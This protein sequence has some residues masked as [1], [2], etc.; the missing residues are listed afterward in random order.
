MRRDILN[1][2]FWLLI[3]DFIGISFGTAIAAFGLCF[4]LI[5][6][7][8]APGGVSALAQVLFYL[9][10][11]QVGTGILV[12]NIPLFLIGIATLGRMFGVKTVFAIFMLGL[13]SNLFTSSFIKSLDFLSPFIFVIAENTISFTNETFLGVVSG[14]V[15]LGLGLGTVINF[16]GSCGS[17]D[18]PALILKKYFGTSIGTGYLLIDT[19]IIL[20]AGILMKNPN[21][22]L[23]SLVALFVTSK[24]TDKMMRGVVF[25]KAVF[26]M[27]EKEDEIKNAILKNINRGCTL[28]YAQGG[29][30]GN[31]KKVI[32]AV[33]NI[34]ELPKLKTYIYVIDPKA[35]V[36]VS[37]VSEVLGEGFKKM[38]FS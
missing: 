16:N 5:P 11:I 19:G 35:F 2:S 8:A 6:F 14:A 12:C 3:R 31:N 28:F 13:F 18:I 30:Y 37:D 36:I 15:L 29:F 32:Y 17:T 26:I 34:H 10:D 33:T 23:W 1:A 24:I 7:K 22:I 9:F 27:T 4:F 20:I 25:A 38:Q 21:V